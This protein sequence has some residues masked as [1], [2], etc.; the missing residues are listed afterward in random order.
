MAIL[1]EHGERRVEAHADADGAIRIGDT[2]YAVT[3]AGPGLVVV[4]DGERRWH[5]AVAG[6][7]DQRWVGVDGQVAVVD[8]VRGPSGGRRT[9]TPPGGGMSAPMPATVVSIAVAP[10]QDV[11][12]G[13]VVVV[14]EAM[15]ME[16]PVRAPRD[17]RVAA[18]HCTPGELVQPGVALVDLE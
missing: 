16:L 18:V 2:T 17:G 7:R 15:K 6:T 11:V 4:S 10:G 8:I 3:P 1:L 13:D 5:V 14:L 12:K 9:R